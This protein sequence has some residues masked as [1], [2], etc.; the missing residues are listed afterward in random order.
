MA[1]LEY[2]KATSDRIIFILLYSL[3]ELGERTTAPD[4]E[5]L[6]KPQQIMPNIPNMPINLLPS[7]SWP[8]E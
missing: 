6:I 4:I 7:N 1:A 3:V 5:V 8:V 2:A